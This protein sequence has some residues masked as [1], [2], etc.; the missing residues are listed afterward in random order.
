MK[1]IYLLITVILVVSCGGYENTK[2]QY[3]GYVYNEN[4]E[5]LAGVTI[6]EF[7]ITSSNSTQTDENGHFKMNRAL[8]NR[9]PNLIFKK[10]GYEIDTVDLTRGTHSGKI[11]AFFLRDQSDTLVMRKKKV[12]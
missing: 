9:V 12:R 6:R 7:D 1:K 8:E 5:A 3:E 10:N 11:S 4:G 2:K